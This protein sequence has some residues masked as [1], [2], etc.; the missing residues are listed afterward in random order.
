MISFEIWGIAGRR[1]QRLN[2]KFGMC[3]LLTCM[4]LAGV[5]QGFVSL[6]V[7][8]QS[9]KRRQV[10]HHSIHRRRT[11]I[12]DEY[13]RRASCGASTSHT[14]CCAY[15]TSSRGTGQSVCTLCGIV[16]APRALLFFLSRVP[17]RRIPNSLYTQGP[18]KL[19]TD[20]FMS[21]RYTGSFCETKNLFWQAL[22][23]ALQS[24]LQIVSIDLQNAQQ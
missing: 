14:N 6:T 8:L 10:A 17:L 13:S 3:F 5:L 16:E 21:S 12:R 7:P 19:T 20:I 11:E 24:P 1:K 15:T 9:S 2:A 4:A 22:E 18:H 23:D